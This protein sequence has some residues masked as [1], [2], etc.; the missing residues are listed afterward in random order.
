MMFMRPP[1]N[2]NGYCIRTALQ[3]VP[4]DRLTALFFKLAKC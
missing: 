1:P 3:Y 4:V 2:C